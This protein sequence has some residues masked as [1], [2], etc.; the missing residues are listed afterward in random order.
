VAVGAGCAATLAYNNTPPRRKLLADSRGVD[1]ASFDNRPID[2]RRASQSGRVDDTGKQRAFVSNSERS[3][4]APPSQT[5][6]HQGL[7]G[8]NS[9]TS[10]NTP[11]GEPILATIFERFA[12]FD[13]SGLTESLTK[14]IVPSW[15]LALPNALHKLQDELSLAPWSV[16]WEI[17]E[18][19]HDPQVNPEIVWDASV[20]IS[21]DLCLEEQQYLEKRKPNIAKALARYLDVPESEVHPDDVPVIAMCGSGGGLRA[22]VAGTSSYL[23]AQQDG[24]FDCATYTAGV[25]GSCWLQTLY[26]SSIGQTSY[27]RLIDHFKERLGVHIAFP[28]AALSL[29][30]QAPTNKFL[31]S[32]IIEKL[33]GVPNAEFGLVDIYGTLLAARLL[34]PK[35]EL[36]VSDWDLKISN[37]RYFVDDGDQPLPI[38]A[39]VRHEIPITP[40]DRR[41]SLPDAKRPTSKNDYF[42]WFEWTPYEFFSEELSAGIPTW[43]VGREFNGGQNVTRENGL[44]LPEIK[45]PLMLVGPLD[46][47]E[48]HNHDTNERQGIW[49]SAFCATLSHYYKEIRPVILGSTIG[50]SLDALL[51]GKDE[52]MTKVHPFDPAS[53]PN[54]ALG[55]R[56]QLPP[57]C[58]ESIHQE[59]HLRLMDA[60]MSNNLPIYPLLRP[61]RGIDVVI[62]FDASAEA[63]KDNWI[64]VVEGYARQRQIKGW[65]MGAGWPP[66][67]E[68]SE[69]IAEELKQVEDRGQQP[70]ALKNQKQKAPPGND[71]SHCTVWIGSKTEHTADQEPPPCKRLDAEDEAHDT[72]VMSSDAG[73][74]VIYFPLTANDKVPGV[75]PQKSDFLSTWNFVYTPEEIESVVS[76]AKANFEEGKEQ[77]RRTIRAVWMRKRDARLEEEKHARN[78]RKRLRMRKGQ[79][80]GTIGVGEGDHFS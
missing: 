75:D 48:S 76:L 58:P 53:I 70:D 78:M 7:P 57:T 25:S 47:N 26:Y 50:G 36:R 68:T 55:L 30:S 45:I 40:Q 79:P 28:P 80:L 66:E 71:L 52:D 4:Q 44:F 10:E 8:A 56:G 59:S 27:G 51:T 24:L 72:H 74:A 31:L 9:T 12:R 20:R 38:Y 73:I 14:I 23:S 35:G 65:P 63:K 1:P 5:K 21:N 3:N 43:A 11:A 19:A 16:S 32:G 60:G 46:M 18:Q 13:I 33:K 17:W 49:G 42:Q 61:G 64:K 54:F 37:Q 41:E 69:E 77:T 62:A 15:A 2:I 22:L 34:V 67:S 29:L 39:A 6:G